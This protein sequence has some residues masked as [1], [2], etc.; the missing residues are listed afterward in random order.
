MDAYR[1]VISLYNLGYQLKALD[2]DH[3]AIRPTVNRE[4]TELIQPIKDD[5]EAACK[6]IRHLPQLRLFIFPADLRCYAADLFDAL[7]GNGYVQMVAIRYARSTG[8]TEWVFIPTDSMA[9]RTAQEIIDFNWEGVI[10]IECQK[11]G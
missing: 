7:I 2:G 3:V 6:A 10:Y 5:P 1:A 11:K 9:D 4:H 8:Q